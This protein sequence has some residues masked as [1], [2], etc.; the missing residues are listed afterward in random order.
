M[1][2]SAYVYF[3]CFPPTLSNRV[4][5]GPPM[6]ARVGADFARLTLGKILE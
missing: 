4:T 5:H 2:S 6:A 3:L 1:A